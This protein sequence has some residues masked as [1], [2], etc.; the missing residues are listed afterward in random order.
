M[1]TCVQCGGGI[2]KKDDRRLCQECGL[3]LYP[4]R[5]WRLVH[6]RLLDIKI[7]FDNEK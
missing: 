4:E 3:V 2:V 7:K 1:A 6:Q 5:V